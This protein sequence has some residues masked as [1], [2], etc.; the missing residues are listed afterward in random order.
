[1]DATYVRTNYQP[2]ALYERKR[3]TRT[4][5]HS[6]KNNSNAKRVGIGRAEM[7]IK[8]TR[9]DEERSKIHPTDD[10]TSRTHKRTSTQETRG[11][12]SM[13]VS[14]AQCSQSMYVCTRRSTYTVSSTHLTASHACLPLR[15]QGKTKQNRRMTEVENERHGVQKRAGIQY[16]PTRIYTSKAPKKNSSDA[17]GHMGGHAH[18]RALGRVRQEALE[19]QMRMV[20][21]V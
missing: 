4:I 7:D 14:S 18:G 2:Q 3:A 5:G 11:T 12:Q 10:Q 16:V 6:A 15:E 1:M 8:E 9:H 17:E 21:Y 19:V 13:S 20:R